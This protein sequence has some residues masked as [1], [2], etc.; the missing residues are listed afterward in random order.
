[1]RARTKALIAAG[2]LAAIGIGAGVAVATSDTDKP[3]SSTS[4]REKAERAA[5]AHVGEGRA[6]E[7]E[8]GDEESYYEVEVRRDDGSQV[9]VQLDRNF[10]VVGQEEDTERDGAGDGADGS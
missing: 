7:T 1:M 10:N 2:V 6:T 9:D 3:I 8:E 4:D 5:V